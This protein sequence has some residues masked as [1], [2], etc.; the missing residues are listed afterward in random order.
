MS[1]SRSVRLPLYFVVLLLLAL[2]LNLV[3]GFDLA[4]RRTRDLQPAAVTQ[5]LE[6][7]AD[8]TATA[9]PS[10]LVDDTSRFLLVHLCERPPKGRLA[11]EQLV[12]ERRLL[13]WVE[14]RQGEGEWLVVPLRGL[15]RGSYGFRWVERGQQ[16]TPG[17]LTDADEAETI[18][19][20][21]RFTLAS[22][23]EV[24][25]ADRSSPHSR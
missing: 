8:S 24:A 5:V 12:G 7:H 18:H 20:L 10:V 6:L 23:G 11:L 9:P 2:G 17:S 15:M 4:R 25:G 16:E 1:P 19:W 22:D 13:R 21:G 3:R 14:T